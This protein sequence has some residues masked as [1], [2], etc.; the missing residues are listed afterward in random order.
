MQSF[1]VVYC[2][3]CVSLDR[4]F[5]GSNP[6]E[7]WIFKGDKIRSTTSF[8]GEVKPQL[9]VIKR[10]CILNNSWDVIEILIGKIQLPFLAQFIHTSLLSVSAA[11]IG[12]FPVRK[13][14]HKIFRNIFSRK[15]S[16]S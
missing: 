12:N 11:S 13:I 5:S 2:L 4:R 10:Y 8:E 9:H 1:S 14:F 7:R 15:F 3:A 6:A 16:V